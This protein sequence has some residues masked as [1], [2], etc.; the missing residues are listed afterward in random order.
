MVFKLIMAA[1]KS[2]RRHDCKDK[3]QLPKVVSGM[4]FRDRIEVASNEKSPHNSRRHR[5]S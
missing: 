5:T 3:N 4:P 1:A 2:W